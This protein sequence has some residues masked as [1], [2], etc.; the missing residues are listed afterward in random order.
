MV[1]APVSSH[2]NV[3]FSGLVSGYLAGCCGLIR[4]NYSVT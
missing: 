3:K 1:A 2:G 4:G